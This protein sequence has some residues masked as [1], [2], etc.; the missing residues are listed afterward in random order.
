MAAADTAPL[1]AT[2]REVITEDTV[3]VL[4]GTAVTHAT[5]VVIMEERDI[6]R[7]TKG[8]TLGRIRTISLSYTSWAQG[9]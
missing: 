3:L 8:T 2:Q 9:S 6:T 1:T 7:D 5:N 4:P